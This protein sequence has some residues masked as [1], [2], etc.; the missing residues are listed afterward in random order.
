MLVL[1]QGLVQQSLGQV[2]HGS[3]SPEYSYRPPLIPEA[4]CQSKH[5]RTLLVFSEGGLPT[6]PTH[7]FSGFVY[8]RALKLS[9]C[10]TELPESIAELSLLRYLDLS[11]SHFHSLPF[12]ISSLRSLQV[13]NLLGCYNLKVLPPLSRITGLRHL[14]ISGC[15][16]LTEIPY[17]IRNLVYLQT[18][19]IYIVP[20]NPSRFRVRDLRFKNLQL[21][22]Q[23]DA[24]HFSRKESN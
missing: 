10:H 21:N 15:E 1:E 11:N 16:A 8:L 3:V 22:I 18:L 13:L 5:L 2:R 6:V 12:A 17:G 9:G 23:T 24:S 19:P 20:K 7:I 14:D 4:L